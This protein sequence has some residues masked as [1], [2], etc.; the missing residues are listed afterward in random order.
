[1]KASRQQIKTIDKSGNIRHQLAGGETSALKTYQAL[2]CGKT[3]FSRFVVYELLTSVLGP[4]PGGAGFFLRKQFYPRL[5]GGF[6]RGVIIGRNVT[7]RHSHDIV[8]GSHVTV[9]DNCVLDARG[10][11]RGG[12]VLEERVLINRNCMLLAKNGPIRMGRRTSLGSNSVVVSMDGVE[13]G[14]AVLTAGG[15]YLSAGSYRFDGPEAVMDQEVYTSGPIRIGPGAWL[16]TRVTVL[17]GVNIGEGAVVGACAMVNRD[18]PDRAIA[19][20]IPAR[21]VGMRD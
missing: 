16:G 15:C 4:M 1:L 11:G 10:A 18:I 21:V 17:D 9:D 7:F 6:G 5:F 12:L 13:T 19:V 3:G 8:L 20:G 14:E 2:T